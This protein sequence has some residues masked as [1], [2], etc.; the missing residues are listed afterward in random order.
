[1][2]DDNKVN[3]DECLQQGQPAPDLA[4]VKDFIRFYISSTHGMLTV[5]PIMSSVKNFAERFF[6]GF[7]CVTKQLFDWKDTQDVYHVHGPVK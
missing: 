4:T 1:M 3:Q 7:T 5:R 6:T 2:S